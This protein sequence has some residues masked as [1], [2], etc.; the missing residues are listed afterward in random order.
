MSFR[1]LPPA[2]ALVTALLV[3]VFAHLAPHHARAADKG[4]IEAFLQVT[5][6]DVVIESLLAFRRAGC[7]GIL[8]Y[9]APQVAARLA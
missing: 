7:D 3:A 6:Y 2:A 1:I 8:T 9:Y 5:G 4:K